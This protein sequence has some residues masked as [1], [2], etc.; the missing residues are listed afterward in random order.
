MASDLSNE[1]AIDARTQSRKD[2]AEYISPN[3]LWTHG[4]SHIY[5]L[6]I[7]HLFVSSSS[8]LFYLIMYD[9][10]MT[11]NSCDLIFSFIWHVTCMYCIIFIFYVAST[12]FFVKDFT[13]CL[14]KKSSR[15]KTF[16]SRLQQ[17]IKSV[18]FKTWWNKWIR[19]G[20][21]LRAW[22]EICVL[23]STEGEE[24][25]MSCFILPSW[26]QKT[27]MIMMWLLPWFLPL[28]LYYSQPQLNLHN[29][30]KFDTTFYKCKTRFPPPLCIRVTPGLKQLYHASVGSLRIPPT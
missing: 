16:A 1:R 27:K 24:M 28:L 23:P 22:L 5:I 21:S 15:G 7:E 30:D 11:P 10:C 6:I 2:C 18:G 29:C 4:R 13:Y 3:I 9:P 8:Q 19:N 14:Q 20:C 12:G 26:K 17:K 25:S